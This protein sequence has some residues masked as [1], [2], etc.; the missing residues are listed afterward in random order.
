MYD[1]FANDPLVRFMSPEE[2]RER[3]IQQLESLSFAE[4]QALA[5]YEHLIQMIREERKKLLQELEG[6]GC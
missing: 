6:L 1:G 5:Q 4:R 3:I 2:Q